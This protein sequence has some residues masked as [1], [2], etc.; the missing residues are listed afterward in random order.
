MGNV[1]LDVSRI[2]AKTGEELTVTE[3]PDNV[4]ESLKNNQAE[5]V[6]MFGR[7]GPCLLYTSPSPRD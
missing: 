2:L 3:I 4:Y 1:A 7:R 5:V 6:H